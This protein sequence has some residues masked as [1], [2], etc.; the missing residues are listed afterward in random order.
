MKNIKLE[1]NGR[2]FEFTFGLRYLGDML[3]ATGMTLAD[4]AKGMFENPFKFVPLI[5]FHSAKSV[6]ESQNKTVDFTEDDFI[7]WI[8]ANDGLFNTSVVSFCENF[9]KSL[10]KRVPKND[11]LSSSSD[12]K[13]KTKK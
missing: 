3:E 13:K 7:D 2:E 11:D 9:T 12:I 10:T 6:I 4:T 8:E 5:M 1:L